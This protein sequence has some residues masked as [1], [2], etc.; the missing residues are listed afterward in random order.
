MSSLRMTVMFLVPSVL[1][2]QQ[3]TISTIVGGGPPE[4]APALDI[5]LQP[6]RIATDASGSIYFS[7]DLNSRV[8]KL[9]PDGILTAVAGNG[10]HGYSG[11]GGPATQAELNGPV[12]VAVDV[13]GNVY[14]AD[15]SNYRVRK[16][17]ADGVITTLAGT[18]EG[19]FSG[20][21]GPASRA[22]LTGP[23]DVVVDDLGNVFIA[24]SFNFRI[25]RISQ[26]GI[27][28]T[29]A[30][31]GTSGF[32]G[33]GGPASSAQ[34]GFPYALALDSDG[35]LYVADGGDGYDNVANDRI[36]KIFGPR[37]DFN[38]MIATI[39]GGG[40]EG[41][42]GDGGPATQA[43][44]S[45]PEDVAVDA[46]GNVYIADWGNAR[47]RVVSTDGIITTFAGTGT[48]GYSG[49]GGPAGT[50]ELNR[51]LGVAVDEAGNVFVADTLR[52][53]KVSRDR[54][55]TTIAGN[56]A[57]GSG[58]GGPASNAQLGYPRD[59]G[60]DAAGNLYIVDLNSFRVLRVSPRG[61]LT[62]FA[63]NGTQGCTG[64]G[65][66]ATNASLY[67]PDHVA[68]DNAG[69]VYLTDLACN[70]VRRISVD[71]IITTIAGNG[72]ARGY[73]GDGGPATRAQLSYPAGLAVDEDGNVYI[74]DHGNFRIR[75]VDRDGMIT[76]IAGNGRPGHS[77]DGGPAQQAGL[78]GAYDLAIG[79]G[80]NLYFTDNTTNRVRKI[81]RDG[82]ISTVAGT[83]EPGYSGDGGQA[84]RA[85]LRTP[86]ALA[87][88]RAGNL[89][90]SDYSN[91]R[92]R[93]IATD[94]TISTIAG[95]GT[96][97]YSGDGGPALQAA[98]G[99]CYGLAV[100]AAGNVYMT[101]A[102]LID[103]PAV[104]RLLEPDGPPPVISAITN[105]ASNFAGAIA[106]GEIVV[107]YHSGIGPAQLHDFHL[108]Q[109]GLVG[110]QLDRTQV[111]FNGTPAPLLYT[112]TT[113]LAA[114]V[115]YSVAA[116]DPAQNAFADVQLTFR[117]VS[118]TALRVPVTSS[119]AT[120]FT[121]DSSGRGQAAALNEDGSY[122]SPENPAKIGSVVTLYAT[123]EGQ[124]SPPGI[125][126]KLG[127]EPLPVP[128]L[129][130]SVVIGDQE[131]EL[132]SAGGA[133]SAVAGLMEVKVKV[134]SG[135]SP[136]DAVP[137]RLYVAGTGTPQG[138]T[139]A[140]AGN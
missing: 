48:S 19:G 25:R 111:T 55:I 23:T 129:P 40:N 99:D 86:I 74:A 14:I 47:I 41:Y 33:D 128:V 13:K 8:W 108:N 2:A 91:N 56:G 43:S 100:D 119:E 68:V 85:Q 96:R 21:G 77:G 61:I 6:R 59:V 29:I 66:P 78:G 50:A 113:S 115:P 117:G 88:D 64:D 39:A 32:S 9:N 60:V 136:G 112:W 4:T 110:T 57:R 73:G 36:R 127:A 90:V 133:L 140:V 121:A 95:N 37:T 58:E 132:V 20:D 87:A 104:I 62:T 15:A 10:R 83:G 130:V 27:I 97:G 84:T 17:S 120:L 65:G 123:G 122:N 114:V 94:G 101:H 26:D 24:D 18:G 5:S 92:I 46:V 12:G 80:G 28:T 16:V 109:A 98:L 34:F 67:A 11:D 49:D 71:G 116:P 63:G 82:M 93:K 35:S 52:L 135:V 134:P 139:I 42:S 70:V 105:A 107:V 76:T 45:F 124:T 102:G 38:G 31:V 54:I 44:L 106:P 53:R 30:G 3:Y 125:D 138:A 118:S 89:Y 79:A 75:K 69:N 131:A 81:S 103:S 72:P 1:A 51:P 22:Q 126:G 137:V 7:D